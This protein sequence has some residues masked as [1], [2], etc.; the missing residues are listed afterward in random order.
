MIQK[1]KSE[2]DS[3]Y[4]FEKALLT[5]YVFSPSFSLSVY[6]TYTQMDEFKNAEGLLFI[7]LKVIRQ[8]KEVQ[9]MHKGMKSTI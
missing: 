5:G 3:R 7:L 8:I 1:F 9:T 6:I 4:S 2:F